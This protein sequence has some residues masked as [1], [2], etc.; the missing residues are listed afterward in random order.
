V[1]DAISGC[2]VT[3]DPPRCESEERLFNEL[4]VSDGHLRARVYRAMHPDNN[5]VLHHSGYI[6]ENMYLNHAE[7]AT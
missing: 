2:Y 5:L 3:D 7:G 1:T 6:L 4:R